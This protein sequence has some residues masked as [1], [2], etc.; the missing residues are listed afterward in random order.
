MLRGSTLFFLHSPHAK[1]VFRKSNCSGKVILPRELWPAI[2][3]IIT[4]MDRHKELSKVSRLPIVTSADGGGWVGVGGWG[5]DAGKKGGGKKGGGGDANEPGAY[6][7]VLVFVSSLGNI[8]EIETLLLQENEQKKR[9]RKGVLFDIVVLHATQ[10]QV[11]S[12][13]GSVSWSMMA[14]QL[15]N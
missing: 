11:C 12:C 6:A 1:E 4:G 2:V 15:G 9:V 13:H 3:D 5:G 7:G 8:K 10:N 14:R